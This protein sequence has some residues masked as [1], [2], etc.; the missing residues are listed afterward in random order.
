[1]SNRI[2]NEIE[3]QKALIADTRRKEILQLH[4]EEVGSTKR[5][6]MWR[7]LLDFVDQQLCLYKPMHLGVE[8]SWNRTP[9]GTGFEIRRTS[10]PCLIVYMELLNGRAIEVAFRYRR[11]DEADVIEWRER[12]GFRVDELDRVQFEHKGEP[13]IDVSEAARVILVPVVKST[14]KPGQ[15]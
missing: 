15:S 12:I 4:R 3:A 2:E 5:P 14:F 10:F 11:S 1:M 6:A 9:N 8:L 13:L 7:E